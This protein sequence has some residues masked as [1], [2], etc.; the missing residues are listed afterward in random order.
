MELFFKEDIIS[1][2]YGAYT[3]TNKCE[4]DNEIYNIVIENND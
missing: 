3:L 1:Y 2:R 4:I